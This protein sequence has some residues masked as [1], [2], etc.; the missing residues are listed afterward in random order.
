MEYTKPNTAA[1]IIAVELLEAL[2]WFANQVEYLLAFLE[3]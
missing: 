3:I 2:L 1:I